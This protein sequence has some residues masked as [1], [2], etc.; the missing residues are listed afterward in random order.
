MTVP[1][2]RADSRWSVLPKKA[3]R[4]LAIGL[5]AAIVV[6]VAIFVLLPS[7]TKTV[8]ARFERAVGLYTGSDVRLHGVKIGT[9]TAV[10]PDGDGVLVTM[11]YDRSVRLPAYAADA[12]VVRAAIIPPSLVS[13]RYV[14]VADYASC[15]GR[16]TVLGNGASIAQNQT[17]SP[18]ELDDIYS[19]LN[20]LNVALGP[21]G[22][23]SK[24]LSSKGPL[25][26]L[27]DVGAANLQGNG[28]ALGETMKN[29]SQAVQTLANGRQDLFGTVKNLQLFTDTLAANDSQ[30][31][32][33]N[34]Q[35]DSVTSELA[36]ERNSISEALKN[37]SAALSDIAAFIKTNGNS[38][39]TDIV[40]L[41]N[42]TTTLNRQKSAINEIL[43]VAPVAVS[44]LTH[45]YNPVSGTLD[46]R[47]NVG[48][49]LDPSVICSVLDK[50][51]GLPV[52]GGTVA[53]TCT[54]ISKLLG[55]LPGIP[56]L[57]QPGTGNGSGVPG[58]P[59]IPGVNG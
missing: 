55:G 34:D 19:A 49:L 26:D 11:R 15:Q 32:K 17:A 10:K 46:T 59:T 43:A 33:F 22:A 9:I 29:L 40:G 2:D 51:V 30:V 13:D 48:G 42:V 56:G 20:K 47:D 5:V 23:N 37:L 7:P 28:Q 16:C 31:R 3:S 12:K 44:N 52:I 57:S 4:L 24:S 53:Q 27:I 50:Q 45:T 39:H 38:I 41:K 36:D 1:A 58:L 6:G 35:L 25:S 14:Q 8:T 54:A 18:V 21:Q